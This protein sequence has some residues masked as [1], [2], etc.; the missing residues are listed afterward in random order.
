[1]LWKQGKISDMYKK[2]P[3]KPQHV[4]K[5]A[6]NYLMGLKE[7][8][9]VKLAHGLKAHE[10]LSWDQLVTRSNLHLLT[11]MEFYYNMKKRRVIQ[12]EIM[13]FHKNP[14]LMAQNLHAYTKEMWKKIKLQ[15]KYNKV[16]FVLLERTLTDDFFKGKIHMNMSKDPLSDEFNEVLE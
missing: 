5:S 8:H 12:N 11:M 3:L 9:M 4:E 14:H 15:H 7:T 10:I 1:M 16:L 2:L 13:V 6:F